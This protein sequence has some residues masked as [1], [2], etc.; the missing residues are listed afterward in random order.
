MSAA[1]PTGNSVLMLRPFALLLTRIG[2]DGERFLVDLGV[3]PGSPVDAY[4]PHVRVDGSLEA[5]AAGRGD[6]SFGI[7]LAREAAT[8]AP[9]GLYGHLIWLSGTLRDALVRGARF[10]PLVTQRATL[11][12][13]VADSGDTGAARLTQRMLAGAA[14][15][16]ILSEYLF[17]SLVLRA[18]RFTGAAFRTRAM[19][20]AH[21]GP[22]DRAG[23]APYEALFG[24]SVTFD[25]DGQGLDALT[26]DASLL[27]LPLSTADPFAAEAIEAQLS[28]LQARA[29]LPWVEQLRLVVR[30]EL[31]AGR[32][33]IP[34]M[35][36]RL[37]MSDRVL[38]RQLEQ[39]GA[40][41]RELVASA[42]AELATERLARG[43]SIKEVAFELGF[44]Q[45]S[46]FSRAYKRWTGKAPSSSR[47]VGP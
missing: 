21:A 42:Q 4:I 44:S 27:D 34:S 37:G 38:R 33:S 29:D 19:H 45:P 40:S 30:A 47:A 11:A 15:G 39:H 12:L 36:R 5:I 31:V 25:E 6:A 9:L 41:L 28:P 13:D 1:H 10:Y 24:T 32:P 14:R 23:A 22:R 16:R 2:I 43:A 18:R 26:F 8:R 17:A 46:A 20:F 7:T 3:S 35:A